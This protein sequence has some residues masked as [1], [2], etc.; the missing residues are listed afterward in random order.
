MSKT[1]RKLPGGKPGSVRIISGIWRS[2]LIT[3]P[4]IP[5]VRPTGDRVRETLFNWLGPYL[6]GARCLDLYA[7]SGVLAFEALSR[8]AHSASLVD[9]DIAVVS[10]LKQTLA[11]FSHPLATIHHADGPTWLSNTTPQ[12][13]DIIFLDPPF[14]S[15]LMEKSL[16][17]IEPA[18]LADKALIYVETSGHIEDLKLPRALEWTKRTQVGNVGIGLATRRA[19]SLL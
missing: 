4:A 17:L 5:G 15:E 9:G 11:S 14:D 6:P 12:A 3:V 1:R 19:Q 18:W 8:G 2:R 10:Q 13:F 7:G 16:S